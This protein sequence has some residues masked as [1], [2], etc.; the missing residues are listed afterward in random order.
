M[1]DGAHRRGQYMMFLTERAIMRKH[2]S[3]AKW[4]RVENKRSD[5]WFENSEVLEFRWW[6]RRKKK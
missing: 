5:H 4:L 2:T 1:I 6:G 3:A